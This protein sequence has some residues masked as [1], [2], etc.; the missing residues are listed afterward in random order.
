M[1]ALPRKGRVEVTTR[2]TPRYESG[3]RGGDNHHLRTC[4]VRGCDGD[5][6]M[7]YFTTRLSEVTTVGLKKKD[8][9]RQPRWFCKNH[10]PKKV[11]NAIDG[12]EYTL[13]ELRARGRY[14]GR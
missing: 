11:V 1:W 2:F 12:Q 10:T 3:Q 14:P 13:K 6:A 4:D 5:D 7:P 8:R 9:N